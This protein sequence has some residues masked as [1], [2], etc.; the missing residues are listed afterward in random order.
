MMQLGGFIFAFFQPRA[1]LIVVQKDTGAK[2]CP[3][4][5]N[6]AP[7]VL[8]LDSGIFMNITVTKRGWLKEIVASQ[9]LWQNGRIS[10]MGHEKSKHKELCQA[11]ICGRKVGYSLRDMRK[12]SARGLW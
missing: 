5:L 3:G 4:A 10:D 6:A 2:G 7:S 11:R 12:A 1:L 9:K 8:S